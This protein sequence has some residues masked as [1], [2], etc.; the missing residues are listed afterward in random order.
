MANSAFQLSTLDPFSAAKAWVIFTSISSTSIKAS[1][2]IS[3]L[4]DNGTGDTTINFSVPFSSA[5]YCGVVGNGGG[6]VNGVTGAVMPI[7][8][9]G[10]DP[11]AGT[12]RYLSTGSTYSAV[13]GAFQSAAFFGAQ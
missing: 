12:A 3:S 6:S 4:T 8:N 1:Y 2:N 13:D 11:T 10:Y 7:G 5:N 9:V